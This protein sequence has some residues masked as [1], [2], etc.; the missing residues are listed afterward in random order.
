MYNHDN[1]RIH[2]EIVTP[3]YLW[4]HYT[5]L[6]WWQKFNSWWWFPIS[7]IHWGFPFHWLLLVTGHSLVFQMFI[8]ILILNIMRIELIV[9][10]KRFSWADLYLHNRIANLIIYIH[11]T[12]LTLEVMCVMLYVW[13]LHWWKFIY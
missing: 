1:A 4:L 10:L 2:R 13:N 12:L 5:L 6:L 11:S 8:Q 3:N 7:F 9:Y